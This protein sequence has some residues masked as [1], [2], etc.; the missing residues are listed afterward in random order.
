[1]VL[2]PALSPSFRFW[3]AGGAP[4]GQVCRATLSFVQVALGL[5]LPLLVSICCWRPLDKEVEAENAAQPGDGAE[6]AAGHRSSGGRALWL[7]IRADKAAAA[8]N[9]ALC[10]LLRGPSRLDSGVLV[11]WWLLAFSWWLCKL[12][13]GLH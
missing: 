1:V 2:T 4:A 13:A 8:G 9:D 3:C 6:T 5:L 12:A 11:C 7:S 10:F